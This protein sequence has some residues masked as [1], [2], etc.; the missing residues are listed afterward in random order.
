MISFYHIYLQRY[1]RIAH[2]QTI[3]AEFTT[4]R[5]NPSRRGMSDFVRP[6]GSTR[7]FY[8][9]RGLFVEI[10]RARDH[11]EF[12][13]ETDDRQRFRCHSYSNVPLLTYL[14]RPVRFVVV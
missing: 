12:C 10:G 3:K 6:A 5:F 2:V 9:N 8:E 14:S 13:R 1:S 4:A 7:R 11:R